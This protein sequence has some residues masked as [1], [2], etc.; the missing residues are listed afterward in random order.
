MYVGHCCLTLVVPLALGFLLTQVGSG[1]KCSVS[2]GPFESSE[3][4][5][6]ALYGFGGS[7]PGIL[8]LVCLDVRLDHLMKARRQAV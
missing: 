7:V 2:Y 4:W 3:P 1:G 6:E 5:T 8:H